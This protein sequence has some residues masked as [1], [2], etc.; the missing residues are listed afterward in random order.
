LLGGLDVEGV[1]GPWK[2]DF[3][4]SLPDEAIDTDIAQAAN[5]SSEL[6]LMMHLSI[7]S[8]APFTACRRTRPH[9]TRAT[10][11]GLWSSQESTPIRNKPT[12]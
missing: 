9:G 6:S 11:R 2:G 12:S 3:V 10:R 1:A 8:T 7:R 4:K 5:A